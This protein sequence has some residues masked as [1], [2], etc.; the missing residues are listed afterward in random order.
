MTPAE[1]RSTRTAYALTQLQLGRA[2]GVSA[3]SV[4]A[5][6]HGLYPPAAY[7]EIMLLRLYAMLRSAKGRKR[8]SEALSRAQHLRP[9]PEQ[10]RSARDILQEGLESYGIY[11]MLRACFR[12]LP[13]HA[14]GFVTRV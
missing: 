6:E 11:V 9:A 1:I 5:W 10:G 3:Q 14:F 2:L 12:D 13:R 4:W 7:H 8:A